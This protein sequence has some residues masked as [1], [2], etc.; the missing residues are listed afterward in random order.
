MR[1]TC[2]GPSL[3]IQSTIA[4]TSQVLPTRSSKLKITVPLP[5]KIYQVILMPVIF[6]DRPVSIAE[7]SLFTRAPE[8]GVYST[9]A[10]GVI[11]S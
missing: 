9:S 11:V 6:S 3:S 1:V 5:V 8:V 7:T 10:V 4:S 2:A